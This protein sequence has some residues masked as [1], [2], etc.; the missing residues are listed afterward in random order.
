MNAFIWIFVGNEATDLIV[1]CGD[2]ET[3]IVLGHEIVGD[4]TVFV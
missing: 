4:A 3:L 2:A 1:L